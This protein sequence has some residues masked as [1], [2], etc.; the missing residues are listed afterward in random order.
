M[1]ATT[2]GRLLRRRAQPSRALLRIALR[3]VARDQ[4]AIHVYGTDHSPWVQAVMLTLELKQLE[5]SMLSTP[6]PKTMAAGAASTETGRST[7]PSSGRLSQLLSDF[8][9]TVRTLSHA[10]LLHARAW[11]SVLSWRDAVWPLSI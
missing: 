10:S 3:A 6:G 8:A 11:L 1:Q 9:P 5:Y 4:P 7:S 2:I